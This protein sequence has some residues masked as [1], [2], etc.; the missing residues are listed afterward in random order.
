MNNL[1]EFFGGVARVTSIQLMLY[2]LSYFDIED[3]S[4]SRTS[5]VAAANSTRRVPRGSD[6]CAPKALCLALKSPA[7]MMFRV[8]DRV[9]SHSIST[10]VGSINFCGGAYAEMK[11]KSVSFASQYIATTSSDTRNGQISNRAL[12]LMTATTGSHSAAMY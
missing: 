6:A 10:N 11:T 9:S 5:L 3:E 4:F 12:C 2:L 8:C 1:Q 7:T